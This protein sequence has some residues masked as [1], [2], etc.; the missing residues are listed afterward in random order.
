MRPSAPD[1]KSFSSA[2]CPIL[3]CSVLIDGGHDLPI[4]RRAQL[5]ELSR[6]AVYYRSQPTTDADLTLMRRSGASISRR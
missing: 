6:S 2:N 1:K 4:T 5:L 3:A